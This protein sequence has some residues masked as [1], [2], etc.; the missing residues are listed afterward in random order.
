MFTSKPFFRGMSI[1]FYIFFLSFLLPTN[2]AAA[3]E[4]F[5]AF[6]LAFFLAIRMTTIRPSLYIDKKLYIFWVTTLIILAIG[7]FHSRSAADSFLTCIRYVEGFAVFLLGISWSHARTSFPRI[8]NKY[9]IFAML[10]FIFLATVPPFTAYIPHYNSIVGINGHH[11]FASMLLV[12]LPFAFSNKRTHIVSGIQKTIVILG[13]ILSG[14]KN[15]WIISLFYI[16]TQP[17]FIR[18]TTYIFTSLLVCALSASLYFSF[19]PYEQKTAI[20]TQHPI[21]NLYIKDVNI[22]YRI[23][24]IQQAVRGIIA[25]PYIGHGPGTFALIS[26]QF[27][28]APGRYATYTHSFML[29][30]LAE[31]G[32]IGTAPIAGLFVLIIFSA[33]QYISRQ[34][35]NTQVPWTIILLFLYSLIDT[36]LNSLPIWIIFWL[37]AGMQQKASHTKITLPSITIPIVTIILLL[38][39]ITFITSSLLHAKG[40][41]IQ[42]MQFAPYR[43]PLALQYEN[44]IKDRQDNSILNFWYAK[45]PDIIFSMR[46]TNSPSRALAYNPYNYTYL[47]SHLINAVITKN[48]NVLQTFICYPTPYTPTRTPCNHVHPTLVQSLIDH[49]HETQIALS[50]LYGND[51]VAKSLYFLG[52]SV[53]KTTQDAD[54][55]IYLLQ[56]ACDIAP[57]WTFYHLALASAQY[58]WKNDVHLSQAILTQCTSYPESGHWCA[59]IQTPSHLFLPEEYAD[60]ITNI[61]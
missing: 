37:F 13:L 9:G 19:L 10:I 25:S 59:K 6:V 2:Q 27:E 48:R 51:G 46:S 55:A 57:Q 45:D 29:E 30:T 50:Y 21:L 34:T 61:R 60:D 20:I 43:K 23:E 53:Y 40:Y 44:T 36:P 22:A 58:H 31:N 11:P 42:A 17:T 4:A 3:L 5:W 28:S 14:A 24:L 49:R 16:S 8:F 56:K 18:R 12:F 35:N 39:S 38:F 41:I 52:L 1:F 47:Q 54:A 32:I 33:I 26:R 7:I 15:A